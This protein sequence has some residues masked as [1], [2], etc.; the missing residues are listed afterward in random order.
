M[1]ERIKKEMEHSVSPALSGLAVDAQELLR[2]ELLLFKR[3]ASDEGKRIVR[4]GAGLLGAAVTALMALVFGAVAAVQLLQ[5]S[6]PELPR[7]ASTG[8]V[9]LALAALCIAQLLYWRGVSRRAKTG[10]QEL[11]RDLPERA[12]ATLEPRVEQLTTAVGRTID[13][14]EDTVELVKSQVRE[15]VETVKTEVRDTVDPRKQFE[16]HP[17]ATF[18][19]SVAVG[20]VAG[21]LLASDSPRSDDLPRGAAGFGANREQFNRVTP[22]AGNGMGSSST[23]DSIRALI[24]GAAI[25]MMKDAVRTSLPRALK[26]SL[27]GTAGESPLAVLLKAVTGSRPKES[28]P[29]PPRSSDASAAPRRHAAEPQEYVLTSRP[30]T[31]HPQ[32][33]PYVPPMRT[34]VTDPDSLSPR[35]AASL[36]ADAAAHRDD[37]WEDSLPH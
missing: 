28:P 11:V 35:A 27:G 6:F 34:P 37:G 24:A 15:S 25:S 26:E 5:E 20:Y 3:E 29:Y 32:E 33:P 16:R 9:T 30:H 18:G 17:V 1:L 10:P 2:S 36:P 19:A 23:G 7:S 13:A 4:M 31:G 12:R 21:R 22:A 8:I 14:A